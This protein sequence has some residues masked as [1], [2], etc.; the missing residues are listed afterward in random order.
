MAS[1][2]S[3]PES[4][5]K[6]QESCEVVGVEAEEDWGESGEDEEEGEDKV[7]LQR[8][9]SASSF[10]GSITPSQ[11]RERETRRGRR[12]RKDTESLGGRTQRNPGRKRKFVKERVIILN[13]NIRD[14]RQPNK[15]QK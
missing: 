15:K 9:L 3:D 2:E 14:T 10:H 11:D 12:E 13:S 6:T 8:T 4:E 7:F 1:T 5:Q